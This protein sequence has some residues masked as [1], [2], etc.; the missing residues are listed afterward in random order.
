VINLC[1]FKINIIEN[2]QNKNIQNKCEIDKNIKFEQS[3]IF[4]GK[5]QNN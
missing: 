2:I 4:S 1:Q 5:Y 3:K